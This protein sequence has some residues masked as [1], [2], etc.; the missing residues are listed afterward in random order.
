MGKRGPEVDKRGQQQRWDKEKEAARGRS[1]KR[2]TGA[3]R[4][5]APWGGRDTYE[6]ASRQGCSLTQ[7][8]RPG[9]EVKEA[10]NAH[11]GQKYDGHKP[12]WHLRVIF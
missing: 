8:M 12:R 11:P 5:W 2:S 6:G 1:E 10:L 3:E 4:S 7:S 9:R